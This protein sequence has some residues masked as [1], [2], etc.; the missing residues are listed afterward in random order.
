MLVASNITK[1]RRALQVTVCA[2]H[3]LLKKAYESE[4]MLEDK[5]TD[6]DLWCEEKCQELSSTGPW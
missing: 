5:D 1:T 3:K 2:L 6:P 4:M